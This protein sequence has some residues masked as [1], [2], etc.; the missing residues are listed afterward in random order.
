MTEFGALLGGMILGAVG[1]IVVW[2]FVIEPFVLSSVHHWV[3]VL[4]YRIAKARRVHVG[5]R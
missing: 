3:R 1:G 5:R 4:A 2:E